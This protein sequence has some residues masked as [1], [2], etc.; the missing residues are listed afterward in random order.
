MISLDGLRNDYLRHLRDRGLE[1]P[2]DRPAPAMIASALEEA[3]RS[4]PNE[5][6]K[7]ALSEHLRTAEAVQRLSGMPLSD[8]KTP[9][10]VGTGSD[11]LARYVET[12]LTGLRD[13]DADA[14][15]AMPIYFGLLPSGWFNAMVMPSPHGR[16][17]LLDTG[18][19]KLLFGFSK[20]VCNLIERNP[21]GI[22]EAPLAEVGCFD[23]RVTVAY[24]SAAATA[25][26]YL[27]QARSGE[28]TV[29]YKPVFALNQGYEPWQLMVANALAFAMKS[30]VMAHEIGHA[31]LGHVGNIVESPSEGTTERPVVESPHEQEFGADKFAFESLLRSEDILQPKFPIAV[32]G[33]CFLTCYLFLLRMRTRLTGQ[34][35]SPDEPSELHPAPLERIR[36]LVSF[37]VAEQESIHPAFLA[38]TALFRKLLEADDMMDIS[39]NT[40]GSMTVG[41]KKTTS[42]GDE[43]LTPPKR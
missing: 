42:P 36:R 43:A 27:Q 23:D 5:A 33:I 25:L 32:G 41:R 13:Q 12:V 37:A 11:D 30:F 34:P 29:Q 9:L 1:E 21:E 40:D 4:H 2:S 26:D 20:A 14:L 35:C 3:A 24:S 39:F 16:L 17:C 8:T 19:A 31:I 7:N 15:R 22:L 38:M 6:L 10:P 18:L 28:H